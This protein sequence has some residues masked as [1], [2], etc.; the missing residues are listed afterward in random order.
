MLTSL[1]LN[2]VSS[3]LNILRPLE[4]ATKEIS[5]NKY[6]TGS[7][8]IPLVRC[9]LC[10]LKTFITNE[11]LV[12]E[13]Q[14]LV[15]KEINKRMVA[16]EQVSSLA[17]ATI[18]DPRFKK[19]HFEAPLACSNAVQTIKEMMKNNLFEEKNNMESDSDSSDK[20]L[21]DFSP[22]SD[23]HKLI[24]RNWKSNKSEE[25]VSDELSG[26]LRTRVS[27]LKENPLEV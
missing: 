5:G 17:I 18:L 3:L 2:I 4:A 9:M 21:E 6:C 13:V 22:W 24:H 12:M 1:E 8:V 14:K 11:P 23:H 15:L 16:I 10:K 27:R 25:S 20:V 19:L 26:Y 7:K